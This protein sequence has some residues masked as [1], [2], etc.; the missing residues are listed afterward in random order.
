MRNAEYQGKVDAIG[1]A[2]AVV[3]FDMQGHVLTA[4]DNFL[5]V[6][7]YYLSSPVCS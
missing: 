4:N 5:D 2:Q 3:E 6:M 7:G 1:K